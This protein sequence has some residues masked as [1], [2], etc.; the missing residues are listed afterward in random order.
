MYGIGK[1][2]E[3]FFRK[4]GNHYLPKLIIDQNKT[5]LGKTAYQTIAECTN[6]LGNEIRIFD[7]T[8]L[9]DIDINNIVVLISSFRHYVEIAQ[10]LE[11]RG[12]KCFFSVFVM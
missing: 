7:I 1:G 4:Y 6:P 8:K 11:N 12:I 3:I 5:L 9:D 2:A 10:E